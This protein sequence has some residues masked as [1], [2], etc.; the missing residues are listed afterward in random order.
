MSPEREGRIINDRGI[1]H[2]KPTIKGT[3]IM[4]TN[5]LSLIG[6]GYDIRGVL[7]YYPELVEE[8][9]KA[10]VEYAIE[11]IEGEDV[12]LFEANPG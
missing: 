5:I 8:D 11:S 2:G 12:Q 4:V 7:Q 10:A 9:V 1:C 3:R 6:G